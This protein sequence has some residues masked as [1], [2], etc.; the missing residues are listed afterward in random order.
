MHILYRETP[1]FFA[2]GNLTLEII[3]QVDK[4]ESG[5][6]SIYINKKERRWEEK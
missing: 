4:S 3:M 1:L 6:C 5:A 2:A